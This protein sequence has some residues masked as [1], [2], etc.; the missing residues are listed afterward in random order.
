MLDYRCY[1]YLR[2]RTPNR[3]SDQGR[4]WIFVGAAA[5]T[6]LGSRLLGLLE[7]PALLHPPGGGLY[8]TTNETIV[9]GFLG[10]LELSQ[11]N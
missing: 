2:A 11:A 8:Y 9:G 5:G 4:Q 10:G 3:I 1:A 7:H 6:L